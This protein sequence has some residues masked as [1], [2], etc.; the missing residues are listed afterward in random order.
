MQTPNFLHVMMACNEEWV[1]PASLEAR[2]F[3]VW[4]VSDAHKDDHA[5]FGAI[6]EEMEAGGYA[7]MLHDL[8]H[9]D[10]TD[11]NVRRVPVTEGL[12]EQKKLSL[13]TSQRMVA[14][15]APP[16]LCVPV[17]ARP[18]VLRQWHEDVATELLY[19]SYCDFAKERREWHP[20]GREAF[21]KFMVDLGLKPCRPRHLASVHIAR[22]HAY[23]LG[24]LAHART[25]FTRAT[26]LSVAWPL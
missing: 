14:R 5:Y 11:F 20:L 12:Q 2:R 19:A 24:T 23:H 4:M 3:F 15:R 25:G 17:Q 9:I 8:L 18:G 21:G 6:W 10:L 26:R 16:R 1:V 7:A 22:P 13:D